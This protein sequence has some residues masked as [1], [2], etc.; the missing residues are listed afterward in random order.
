MKHKNKKAKQDNTEQALSLRETLALNYRAFR[1]LGKRCPG[2]YLLYFIS[3]VTDAAS[4]YFTI[5]LSARLINELAGARDP[6]RLRTLVLAILI[7]G[8]FL[9]LLNGILG[10]LKNYYLDPYWLQVQK[11]YADKLLSMDFHSMDSQQTHE[12]YSQIMQLNQWNNWGLMRVHMYF[13][14]LLR[15]LTGV[16][17]A[18][19]LT[20]SLFT[21]PVP[22]EAGRL[23]LLNHP[24]AVFL[25]IA[26]LAA[27]TILAPAC[28][29]KAQEFNAKA[30]SV[31]TAGNRIFSFYGFTM[32]TEKHRAL[33]VRMY[34]QQE[35]C[36]HHLL[37]CK[38]FT[39]GGPMAHA[40]AGP[41]GLL[42]ALSSALSIVFTGIVYL[43]TCLKA[44]AGAFGVGSVT[45]YI[46]AVTALSRNISSLLEILGGMRNNA[47]F[48][49]T[50][51][52]FLDI[53]DLMYQGSLTTEKRA[54]CHYQ[55]EFRDV[56]FRYPGTDT[57]ALRHVSMQ[58]QIGRRLAVVGPNGSGKSTFIKLLCRLYDPTEGEILLN[59]IDI[60]KY[61]YEDYMAL[62]SVVFQDFKLLAF[63]LGENVA[64][65]RPYDRAK[66]AHCL[67]KAGFG[68][69]LESL[70]KG[71]DT[72]LY[73]NFEEDGVEI[74]GGEAQKI[75][76]ARAL[77]KNAPFLILD[78]PTAAL[79][80]IAEMEIYQQFDQIA[81]D[82]TAIYISHR[83]SSCRFCDEIAVF[84]EGRFI[85]QGAHDT[86][87]QEK[88]GL[89]HRL[90]N[91]QA[92]YYRK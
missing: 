71:L 79:D 54:D 68:E 16:V 92:Q 20:V 12:L 13:E 34:N 83:L 57:Y 60:R 48:L 46:S 90:W 61:K 72:C 51:F 7:T 91:A 40:A 38:S 82:K 50:T 5:W 49:R 69:R 85:Q 27:I 31:A 26:L 35:I 81:R 3:S 66:A 18:V 67:E 10:R 42:Y 75:A 74:S 47:R 88:D 77:Y 55:V 14:Y 59:G 41:V 45:Q 64:A 1:L 52:E 86:L 84:E 2:V 44:W 65:G 33:D 87:L 76:I 70:G 24:L 8:A 25:C 53:P 32:S 4:P 36:S 62:F 39:P 15:G 19:A 56:S 6:A 23:V 28:N 30:A 58:F 11:I 43:F 22:Q 89:Y 37:S 80:P 9:A 73:R 21:L 17:G 78:E 63:P 29:N